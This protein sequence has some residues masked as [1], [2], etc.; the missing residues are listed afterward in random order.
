[1]DDRVLKA[2]NTVLGADSAGR[3]EA[4]GAAVTRVKPGGIGMRGLAGQV[5]K[6]SMQLDKEEHHTVCRKEG[7]DREE[8]AGQDLFSVVRYQVPAAD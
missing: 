7:V 1:M 6:P 3:V 4:V 5:D 8:I 2:N